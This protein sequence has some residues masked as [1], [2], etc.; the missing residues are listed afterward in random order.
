MQPLGDVLREL[1]LDVTADSGPEP[2]I[3]AELPVCP[4]CNGFGY[5]RRDL[6]L[7]HPE[8]GQAVP[9]VCR[10][11]ELSRQ[12]QERLQRLANLGPLTR[13]TFDTLIPD[14][15]NPETEQHRERFRRAMSA[16]RRFAEHPEGWL[17]FVG[18]PGCGKTH[19]A[20]AVGN[21]CLDKGEPVLFVVVPDLLD[22]LRAA[23]GP[24][25]ETSYDELFEN[26][27]NHP[28]LILDDLG[29][30]SATAW[31][32]E[33]LFQLLNTRYNLRL[34]TI[35]TTNR[36]LEEMDERLRVRLTD[37]DLA[38]VCWV[39]PPRSLALQHL[40][41]LPP[42]LQE[43]QFTTF[44]PERPGLN[45]EQ[46]ESLRMALESART[47]AMAPTGWL[48]LQGTYGCGKTHLAAAI[49]NQCLEVGLPATFVCVPDLLDH[50]RS[51]FG[52]ESTVTYDELFETFRTGPL[53]ILDDL[54]SQ[55]GTA[56]AQEKLYQLF[57]YRYNHRLP[58]VV[59]TNLS[60]DALEPRLASRLRDTNLARICE[61][62]APDYRRPAGQER[63]GSRAQA[64]RETGPRRR[65]NTVY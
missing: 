49:A 13:L 51:T 50:L 6:P 3:E 65:P 12:R 40:G 53:L 20:A 15:R 21:A 7:G 59:T 64:Y 5:V 33:K 30:Q 45:R 63:S 27:R 28:L 18:P 35:L 1:H 47:F 24:S 2:E 54:G 4:R 26:V 36:T 31:A 42:L 23:F 44:L 14:G 37:P 10:S 8:F 62:S 57:N 56:W 55:S 34:P 48:L 19:L 17:L 9:C 43:M 39:E 58:T 25:S 52:P 16:A 32:Q 22:H 11:D 61:I 41:T 46:T 38:Q 29:T 60:F